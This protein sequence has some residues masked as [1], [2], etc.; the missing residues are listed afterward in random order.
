MLVN[1]PR[2]LEGAKIVLKNSFVK[3]LPVSIVQQF[4]ATLHHR[5]SQILLTGQSYQRPYYCRVRNIRIL[6]H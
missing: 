1:I 5:R 6:T 4:C 3:F 2:R